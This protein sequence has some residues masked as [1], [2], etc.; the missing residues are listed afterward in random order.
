MEWVVSNISF[1]VTSQWFHENKVMWF[2]NLP[3]PA[4]DHQEHNDIEQTEFII[5]CTKEECS[6][7]KHKAP[8]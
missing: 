3:S 1:I 2:V 5:H 4:I 7:R 6:T 8:Q